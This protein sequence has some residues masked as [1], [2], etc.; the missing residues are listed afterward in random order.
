MLR[1]ITHPIFKKQSS[2]EYKMHLDASLQ[3]VFQLASSRV[4]RV[5]AETRKSRFPHANVLVEATLE[6]VHCGRSVEAHHLWKC[7]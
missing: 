5:Q 1:N 6:L 7:V 4:I 2:R 3:A